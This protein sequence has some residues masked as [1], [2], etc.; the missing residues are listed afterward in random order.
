MRKKEFKLS[1][2]GK[3]T[4]LLAMM[5][6]PISVIHA[7]ESSLAATA[8]AHGPDIHVA[9]NGVPV[10]NI[11]P[12][13]ASGMSHNQ[14]EA[15]NVGRE[16]VVFNN[17][18]E[19]VNSNAGQLGAN[20]NLQGN[21]ASLILNEVVGRNASLLLGR[22]QVVG[23]AA[24]YVLANPNGISCD[25]CSFDPNFNQVTL[26]VGQSVVNNGALQQFDAANN[27]QRMTIKNT[28]ATDLANVLTLI[29]PTIDADSAIRAAKDVNVIVGQN[30]V[31]SQNEVLQSDTTE[32]HETMIDG[33][34]LGSIAA[35]RIQL[36]DT[37]K[38]SGLTFVGDI[39]AQEELNINAA[40]TIWL[41]SDVVKGE[42]IDLQAKNI[43]MAKDPVST[44]GSNKTDELI[45]V[46]SSN[47]N[48]TA[49]E[50]NQLTGVTFRA[51]DVLVKGSTVIIEGL[52]REKKTIIDS[53]KQGDGIGD[54]ITEY[55]Q[56]VKKFDESLILGIDS[57]NIEATDGDLVIKGTN[58]KSGGDT[59]LD[60]SRDLLLSGHIGKETTDK[61][62]VMNDLGGDLKNGNTRE[63]ITFETL[64]KTNI[65][66][67]GNAELKAGRNINIAGVKVNVDGYLKLNSGNNISV[68]PQKIENS[69]V[70]YTGFTQWDALG[71][72][73]RDS[74]KKYTYINEPS[75][76]SSNKV[77]INAN[78]NISIIASK[79]N[80]L[81][82]TSIKASGDLILAGVLNK[83]SER[84]SKETGV[85]FNIII[86][87]NNKKNSN[88]RFIDTE[89]TS[90][91]GVALDSN[92]VFIDGA[93]VNT[94]GKLDIDAK[95]NFVVTAARQQ[96]QSDEQDSRLSWEWFAKKQKDKQY[97]AGFEIK[98]VNN[99][100][101][102]SKTKSHFATLM[103]KTININ[104]DKDIRFYG[105]AIKTNQGDLAL[106]AK[107][108]IQFL[109][110]IDSN[111]TDK[112]RTIYSGGA[113][114]DGG[115]DKFGSGVEG[116]YSNN[117]SHELTNTSIGA[118]TDIN[119][120]MTITAGEDITHQGAQHQV[121][122]K[123]YERA[124]N[125]YH[126]ASND[127]TI[128][129]STE[130]EI[131]AGLGFN[132]NYSKYTR[133][134]EKVIKDP[135]NVLHHLGG[136]G[137]IKGISDPNVGVDIYASGGKTTKSGLSSLASVT[138]IAAADIT[139]LARENIIDDGTQYHAKGINKQGGLFSLDAGHHFSHAAI[140]SSQNNIENEK[141]E[142]A[143]RVSTMTG[144]DIKVA[145]S[146][147]GET[148]EK[149]SASSV[150]LPSSIKAGSN[151]LINTIGNA[152]YQATEIS[153]E[154][155]GIHIKSGGDIHFDQV[156]DNRSNNATG[157]HGKGKL[158]VGGGVGSKELRLELGGGYQ[159]SHG[160]ESNAKVG[161]I[162][163]RHAVTLDASNITLIG[164][165][166][167]NE[168][169]KVGNVQM[170]AG[171]K[172]ILGASRSDSAN[173]G[174]KA[175]GNIRVGGKVAASETDSS[176]MGFIGGDGNADKVN[177]SKV[178]R[179]GMNIYSAGVVS[180]QAH[181]DD[182][183]AIYTQ[184]L[185]VD[186]KKMDINTNQGGILMESAL[187]V[188]PKDNWNFDI[189]ADLV[190]TGKFNK[191][192]NGLVDKNSSSKSHYTGA[193]I[194]VA[195][196]KQDV[197][198]H[199][200]THIKTGTFTLKSHKDTRMLGA[201]VSADIALVD[202][203]GDLNIESR[204][205]KQD[206]TEVLVNFALS[207]TN[208]KNS[209]VI[210]NL[211]KIGTKRFEGEIKNV[212]TKGINKMGT[213]YNKKFPAKDTMGGVSFSKDKQT[214]AL[215][216]LSNK[217]HSRNLADKTARF[218]GDKFKTG[219]TGPAGFAGHANLD[220]NIVKND[221]VDHLSGIFAQK[222][223]DIKVLGKTTLIAA[224]INNAESK[225][226]ANIKELHVGNISNSYH[227]G[228]GGFNL[229]ST[230]LGVARG[231]LADADSG[232]K[233]L[234]RAPYNTNKNNNIQGGI[235]N[236]S[237]GEFIMPDVPESN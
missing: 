183:Q 111:M 148:S 60:A 146:A 191:D 35:N 169:A 228:G 199:Q 185:Q 209:S 39:T 151:V 223:A 26:V 194:K 150:L 44:K 90:G 46:D 10:I 179:K 109:A 131:K 207:H 4:V 192:S 28:A 34:F 82:D 33:Y 97:R 52:A 177:E 203:G 130:K 161:Q 166:I 196:D 113:H 180:L 78:E 49:S 144:K 141:G 47:I 72:S 138:E 31:S 55:T 69:K 25:G 17:S 59:K 40:G 213:A 79:V 190:L 103:G 162:K 42:S 125:I 100:E 105:T 20:P 92:N 104:A 206:I 11:A 159:K 147:A 53:D 181:S 99:K 21:A 86:D 119:G 236:Y 170:M 66:A 140:N 132:I 58:L 67:N 54:K 56:S 182:N 230:I 76:L 158:A 220:V 8:G 152:Y 186:A 178:V 18:L 135:A 155:G 193:G 156:I 6:T 202:V 153:S 217:T 235:F 173:N 136:T 38:E 13:S 77:Y 73:E 48:I 107:E 121:S 222:I 80:A 32:A 118:K 41:Q 85:A 68:N 215:P 143:I 14:Y 218:L 231:T 94:R 221:T 142:G 160:H 175:G 214:V 81:N 12:P 120:N 95:G 96:Q 98:H 27:T 93:L 123:Y 225:V 30:R 208:D 43:I 224:Q 15:F 1:P 229:A 204:K 198:E 227:Q 137:S 189:N 184:G 87:S 176:K 188:L 51:H 91:N 167:G 168:K 115:I 63:L 164:T 37:R 234:I 163:A 102:N 64:G 200:N 174:L 101:K 75:E 71:G 237:S 171:Q 114:Y 2:A 187:T 126:M 19:S 110:A 23:M 133:Q 108:G 129:N 83:T 112:E 139:L 117:K 219:L 134:I 128:S 197:V 106:S 5:L 57:L 116:K 7:A 9:T 149:D 211:S 61:L 62:V 74:D 226:I 88:E 205:D 24:D 22:Q 172:L 145:L 157:T 195:V 201:D 233:L 84:S 212:L 210:S 127:K 124:K 36:I 65:Y 154:Q 50:N 3:L 232:K 16:G 165:K 216:P 122:G 89:I 29:T 70:S 45:F